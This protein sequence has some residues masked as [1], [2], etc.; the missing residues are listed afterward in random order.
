M[1]GCSYTCWR[2]SYRLSDEA[3]PGN[4]Y[5]RVP[6][7]VQDATTRLGRA[8]KNMFEMPTTARAR[9]LSRTAAPVNGYDF[10]NEEPE[11]AL[12]YPELRRLLICHTLSPVARHSEGVASGQDRQRWLLANCT[13]MLV[14]RISETRVPKQRMLK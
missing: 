12:S 3:T 14:A 4:T 10:N 6:M 7:H 11:G 8:R 5:R 9:D 13:R 2:L 1:V